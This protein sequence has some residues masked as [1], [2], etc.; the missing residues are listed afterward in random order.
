MLL[1]NGASLDPLSLKSLHRL[2]ALTDNNAAAGGTNISA[3]HL[4]IENDDNLESLSQTILSHKSVINAWD[5]FGETPLTLACTLGHTTAVTLLIGAGA[6]VDTL[7]SRHLA[8]LNSAC[9]Q[10]AVECVKML[11]VAKCDV[12][13][14]HAFRPPI[15]ELVWSTQASDSASETILKLLQ[16]YGANLSATSLFED[17]PLQ[18]SIY[19]RRLPVFHAL[20]GLG[21]DL[22]KF[23]GFNGWT[24]LHYLAAFGT[25]KFIQVLLEEKACARLCEVMEYGILAKNNM[26]PVDVF[27]CSMSDHGDLTHPEWRRPSPEEVEAFQELM[28]RHRAARRSGLMEVLQRAVEELRQQDRETLVLEQLRSFSRDLWGQGRAEEGE[29]L[30]KIILSLKQEIEQ[31][32]GLEQEERTTRKATVA[33]SLEEWAEEVEGL[34]RTPPLEIP[35]WVDEHEVREPAEE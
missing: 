34:L 19:K 30:R 20:V 7:S 12:D 13:A 14:K 15:H 25:L 8:P 5:R 23:K 1:E 11:L 27:K 35:S 22:A 17:W 3:I 33:S 26:T 32:Q 16:A 21:A 9:F 4:A 24:L 10:G 2:V 18:L 6:N 28:S 31:G 29:R